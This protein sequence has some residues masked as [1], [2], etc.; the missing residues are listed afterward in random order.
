MLK[1]RNYC[2][3]LDSNVKTNL[4]LIKQ[5]KSFN[6]RLQSTAAVQND[7]NADATT[8]TKEWE[9]AK[10]YKEIPTVGKL[11]FISNFLPGG[12]YADMDSTQLL[13]AF[14]ADY[15]NISRLPALFWGSPRAVITHN[16]EDFEK[17]L[18]NEGIW[19]FRPGS[20]AMLY[21]RHVLRADFFQGREGLLATQGETWGTFRSAVNP[22][23]MQPK[24]CS[25][26]SA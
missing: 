23:M 6:L 14:K 21:H 3:I 1:L 19:P 10:P 25:F 20:E 9:K 2:V 13:N 22:V 4:L 15:G 7:A 11:K 26:V 16:V 8:V 24:N 17:V 5:Q 12:K 18:R